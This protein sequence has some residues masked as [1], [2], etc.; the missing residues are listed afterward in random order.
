MDLQRYAH[1]RP[2]PLPPPFRRVPASVRR[3]EGLA[4]ALSRL[5]LPESHAV[6]PGAGS[7]DRAVRASVAA[8]PVGAV[9]TGRRRCSRRA[10]VGVTP[11]SWLTIEHRRAGGRESVPAR[12]RD[13]LER[14]SGGASAT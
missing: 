12:S 7:P 13:P 6:T 11:R 8:P 3:S 14:E 2:R 1:A 5:R 9:A 4:R 10:L